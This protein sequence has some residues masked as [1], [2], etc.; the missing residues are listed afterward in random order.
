MKIILAGMV[1]KPACAPDFF[2]RETEC[3]QYENGQPAPHRNPIAILRGAAGFAPIAP[4]GSPGGC[5]RALRALRRDLAERPQ[6]DLFKAVPDRAPG[7]TD[8]Y[9]AEP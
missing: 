9:G 3:F 6:T 2:F 5:S 4:A 7:H 8:P 1:T